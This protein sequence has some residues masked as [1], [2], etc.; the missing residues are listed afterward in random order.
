LVFDSL[1]L[2]LVTVIESSVLSNEKELLSQETIENWEFLLQ[3]RFLPYQGVTDWWAEADGGFPP[4]F[5]NWFER[6][7]STTDKSADFFR[8]KPKV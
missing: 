4:E 6:Q 7:I 2:G 1:I 8:I 5:R 3:T